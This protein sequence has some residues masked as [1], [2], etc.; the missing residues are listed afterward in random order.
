MNANRIGS[1]GVDVGRRN[2]ESIVR[3]CLMVVISLVLASSA[4]QNLVI[5]VFSGLLFISA[6]VSAAFAVLM[7][8]HPFVGHFTRWDE[9]AALLGIGMA[10]SLMVDPSALDHAIDR[11]TDPQTLEP[12]AATA[13][14]EP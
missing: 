9:T 11:A 10:A 3:V 6:A 5:A 14:V 1:T 7:R 4:P 13:G 8:D 12:A 2:R